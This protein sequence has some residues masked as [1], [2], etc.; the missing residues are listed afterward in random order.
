MRPLSC[1]D[2]A[3]DFRRANA[4]SSTVFDR[5]RQK[6]NIDEG[7]ILALSNR[8]VVMDSFAST[9]LFEDKGFL[10]LSLNWD[11]DRNRL[12]HRLLRRIAKEELCAMVPCQN[13]AVEIL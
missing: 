7:P 11:K 1:G 12:P 9:D 13:S 5:R 10:I 2:I 4:F 3:G 8:L 6:G